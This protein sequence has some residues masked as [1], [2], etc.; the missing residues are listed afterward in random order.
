[1]KFLIPEVNPFNFFPV[2][3]VVVASFCPGGSGA[4]SGGNPVA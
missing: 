1:M 3:I 4:Q 2:L